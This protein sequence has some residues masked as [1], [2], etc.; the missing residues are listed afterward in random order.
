MK[1]ELTSPPVLALYDPKL[2]TTLMTDAAL[3]GV[4]AV[5][6][7]RHGKVDRPVA[8]ISRCL[9]KHEKNWTTTELELLA[10]QWAL[11]RL[12]PFVHG[13]PIK[14]LTDHHALCWM[15]KSKSQLTP[16]LTR[17]FEE[18][19]E[20]NIEG[21]H[22]VKGSKHIVAD[23]LSRFPVLDAETSKSKKQKRAT[24][25]QQISAIRMDQQLKSEKCTFHSPIQTISHDN[26]EIPQANPTMLANEQQ[27]DSKIFNI[28]R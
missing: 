18:I 16:R 20:Y 1:K 3:S 11:K 6:T 10:I 2:P 27:K 26:N 13:I 12:K 23:C 21:I 15:L 28:I 22:H 14:I 9:K 5:L 4:G 19:S 24:E 8:F 25:N 17:M 7:Q